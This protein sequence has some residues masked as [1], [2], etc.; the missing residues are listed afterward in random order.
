MKKLG[1]ERLSGDDL[2]NAIDRWKSAT[3]Q[4]ARNPGSVEDRAECLHIFAEAGG[5]LKGAIL[6]AERLFAT[7]GPIQLMSGHKSK[8]LEFDTVFFLDPW[9]LP[10]KYATN[11]DQLDQ[12]FN[13]RYVIQTRAKNRLVH[14]DLDKFGG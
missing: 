11:D 13:L 14:V 4:S 8:G 6:Y 1:D 5:D 2:H 12:E 9:R 3:L 10:S 7:S